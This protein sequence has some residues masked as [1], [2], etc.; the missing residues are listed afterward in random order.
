[1][2]SIHN[3]QNT[4]TWIAPETKIIETMM[5]NVLH[6]DRVVRIDIYIYI[7]HKFR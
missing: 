4:I 6:I 3:N 1:M 5:K 2:I 7:I